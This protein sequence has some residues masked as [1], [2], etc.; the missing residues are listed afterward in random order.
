MIM[1]LASS[2][3]SM[4][5]CVCDHSISFFFLREAREF[6]R[7]QKAK[8]HYTVKNTISKS[9]A[10]L[11]QKKAKSFRNTL[12]LF[13]RFHFHSTAIFPTIIIIYNIC[14]IH[15]IVCQL[16]FET[17]ARNNLLR[18]LPTRE[19]FRKISFFFRFLF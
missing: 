9:Q 11:E 1:N 7:A 14:V 2:I 13:A 12:V 4:Y 6:L 18:E 16:N 15:K 19:K 3:T 10:K 8:E 5:A 17:H